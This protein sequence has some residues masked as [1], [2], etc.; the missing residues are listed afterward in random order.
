MG[1]PKEKMPLDSAHGPLPPSGSAS[2]D[3][4]DKT[5]P[6]EPSADEAQNNRVEQPPKGSPYSGAEN[7]FVPPSLREQNAV[8]LVFLGCV[9]AR[10]G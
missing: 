4:E 1:V 10:N 9:F 6:P 8:R 3:A 5:S 2:S 7:K